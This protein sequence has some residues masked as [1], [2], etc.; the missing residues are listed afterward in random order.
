MAVGFLGV[1]AV[2]GMA[3]A[4]AAISAEEQACNVVCWY[5]DVTELFVI[6]VVDL[7]LCHD[8]GL[9]V[10]DA[11]VVEDEDDGPAKPNFFKSI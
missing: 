11:D 8:F 4:E 10:D 5:D 6:D 7:D 9:V 2:D 1:V 3:A